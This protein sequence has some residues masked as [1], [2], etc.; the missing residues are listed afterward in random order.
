MA[1]RPECFRLDRIDQRAHPGMR[2]ARHR[3][4]LGIALAALGGVLDRAAL[5]DVDDLTAEQRIALGGQP[6]RLGEVGKG[7]DR[8]GR[9]VR[10]GPV[11]MDTRHIQAER[12]QPVGIIRKKIEKRGLRERFDRRPVGSHDAC[13]F[14]ARAPG[15]FPYG[16]S[17]SGYAKPSLR[18]VLY[19]GPLNY[20]TERPARW[21][22]SIAH[23]GAART[24]S[25]ARR[26]RYCR[27]DSDIAV[28]GPVLVRSR[29]S[30]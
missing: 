5:G 11:E 30:P 15:G 26:T 19:V 21:L 13:S 6:A 29:A 18:L 14:L 22:R 3:D 20:G 16:V 25:P 8:L 27:P 9:Q 1:D 12:G 23:R 7:G 10:L 28:R 17:Q 4:A 2:L 24:R